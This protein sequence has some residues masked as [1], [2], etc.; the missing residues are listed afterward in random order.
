[1][2]RGNVAAGASSIWIVAGFAVFSVFTGTGSLCN[3]PAMRRTR[4][5][6]VYSIVEAPYALLLFRQ[7]K[8]FSP[9][10]IIEVW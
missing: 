5:A 9:T 4:I 10:S 8:M 3:Q 6:N 1:V 2:N 7:V